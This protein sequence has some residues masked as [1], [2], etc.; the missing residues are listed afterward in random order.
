MIVRQSIICF[1]VKARL[2]ALDTNAIH[3]GF[4]SRFDES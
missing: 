4:P 2:C 1:Q 3:D